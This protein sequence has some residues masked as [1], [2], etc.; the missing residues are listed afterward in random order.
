MFDVFEASMREL[1]KRADTPVLGLLGTLVPSQARQAIR[2]DLRVLPSA[3]AFT[4]RLDRYPALFGVWLAEHVMLG[5]GQDGHFSLYPHLQKAVGGAPEFT[6]AER[7]LLWRAFRRAMLKLGIQPLSRRSGTHYMADEYV[8]QA[9]VPIAFADDLAVRMLHLARK[10]GLPDE[11]DQEGLLTWQNTLLN[12]LTSPF[13]LTARKAVERDAVGYYTHAFVRVY[14]NGGQATSQDLLETAFAKAFSKE[15]APSVRRTAIPQLLYRDGTLGILFPPSASSV[16]YR[17]ESGEFIQS[18]RVESQGAY[19][20]IPIGLPPEVLVKREDGERVLS[21]K[22]WPDS[23]SNRLLIFNAEGRLRASGQLRQGEPLELPPGGYVALCRF[24]PTNT[25]EW[26]E[27]CGRPLLVEVPMEIRPGSERSLE[28]GPAGITIVGENQPTFSLSGSVKGSLERLDFW[29][30]ELNAMVEVP[31]EWLQTGVTGFD[32]RVVHGDQKAAVRVALNDAGQAKVWVSAAIVEL[33]VPPGMRRLVLE[34]ARSGEARAFQRQSILYWAGLR[35]ITYGLRFSYA[36]APQNLITSSCVGLSV[37]I[38]QLVPADDQN[39]LLRMAFDIGGGRL[40]HLSWHRPGVFVE[41]Q[42]PNSDG[43]STNVARALGAAE[44]VSLT[45][46]K[47]VMVSASEPGYISLGSMRTFV[48]FAKRGSKSF[49]ASFLAS[50]LESGAQTL[51]YESCSGNVFVPLLVLSQ[52]H[53]ATEVKTER[54]ANLLAVRIKVSGEPTK[55][56]VTGRELS[57]GRKVRAEHA[58]MAGTW[59]NN[60]LARMQVYYSNTG[61]SHVVHM[62]MDVETLNRGVWLLDFGACVGGVWGRLQDCD[63]GRIVVALAVDELGR[64]LPGKEVVAEA[65]F[66]QLHEVV[67]RLSRLNEHFRE[68]LSPTCW[69]HQSWLLRYFRALVERLRDHEDSYVTELADMAMAQASDDVRPGYM[70]MQ[71]VPAWLN[72]TFALSR[73]NYNRVNLKAHPFSIALRAMPMLR[74]AVSPAFGTVLHPTAAMPFKNRTDVMR[75]QRPR[76]FQLSTYRDAL[77]QTTLQGAYQLDDEL[78][79]PNQGELLGPLHLAHAWRDLERGFVTS[80][81]MLNSSKSAAIAVARL[82]QRS[83]AVFDQAVPAGLRAQSLLLRPKGTIGVELDEAEQ[84][85]LEHMEHIAHA[86]AWLAWYCRLE[87]RTEGALS[88]FHTKLAGLRTQVEI[89]GA[90]VSD[91]VAYYL[92]VAPAIFAFYLLLWELVLTVE[93]DPA[94]QNV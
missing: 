76:D 14:L 61:S 15:G 18:V 6:Q 53:V 89:P 24:E 69:E 91:C 83:Y 32:V 49:P 5:L 65:E 60:D 74:G 34:L 20:P 10:I 58:L 80:Q 79:I 88:S 90:Q 81:L 7:E 66:L 51:T 44:T 63:E 72:R 40:V 2:E 87:V 33:G 39:R 85:R 75:G 31:H 16:N 84:L 77:L 4:Q 29:Y 21:V 67:A 71:S 27:V 3:R 64:E 43:S 12:K 8:R 38:A 19:R 13:S 86:C 50:R 54:L 11:D 48:D 57:S 68:C 92:Q 45:S 37:S 82:L 9:G 35:E 55:V 28:N 59:H 22:L 17:V 73:A 94:V 46:G 78:F 41:I 56:S 62:L 25:D 52:P 23:L 42:V 36:V 1:V 30:G 26:T 70:S 93:L 47:T